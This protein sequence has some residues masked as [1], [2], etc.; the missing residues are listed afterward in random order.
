MPK[1]GFVSIVGRPNAGK[2]SFLNAL[3]GEKLCPVTT[4]PQTTRSNLRGIL[5]EEAGQIV[6]I[7]TP[8]MHHGNHLINK[9]M[10]Q[11]I[12]AS[13][14]KSE[15]DLIIYIIDLSRPSGSEEDAIAN[16]LE[17][18]K[19]DVLLLFNKADLLEDPH[20]EKVKFLIEHPEFSGQLAFVIS[21]HELKE[22]DEI[23][24]RIF[25]KLPEGE[26]H[27]PGDYYTD[28]SMRTIGA[29]IIRQQIIL[30]TNEEVPHASCVLIDRWEDT[31]ERSQVS[32]SIIVET[33]GQKAILIGDKGKRIKQIRLFS[34]KRIKEV[35]G[36]PVTLELMVKVREKWRN[37]PGFLRQMGMTISKG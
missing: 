31:D 25:S 35:T 32:A 20:V 13:T 24:A 18:R 4:M 1:F 7:D 16:L 14:A 27:F 5:T 36:L 19:E 22:R 34:Q 8:G 3:L 28:A 26:P 29:D 23:V 15:A 21:C 2:S 12:A 37:N 9:A 11:T 6:F 33:Q 10:E 17:G 30:N